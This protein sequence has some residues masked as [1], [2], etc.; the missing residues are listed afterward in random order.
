MLRLA[1]SVEGKT[2]RNFVTAVIQPHFMRNGIDITPIDL[3]GNVSVDRASTEIRKFSRG[4]DYV[5]TFYDF[6]GFKGKTLDET[7]ESL[8]ARLSAR[9]DNLLGERFIPYIQMHEFEGLLFSSPNVLAIYLKDESLD[10]W[11]TKILNDHNNNPEQINDS[12]ISAPS[13]RLQSKTIYSKPDLGPVIAKE[14]GLARLRAKC[15]GFDE[16]ITRIERL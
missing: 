7:T 2:E 4:F 12:A 6:Y 13:K 1:V 15:P 8:E 16:W 3:R 11:A 5:T 9:L 10:S 14:I